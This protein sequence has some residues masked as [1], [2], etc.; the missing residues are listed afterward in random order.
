MPG[1]PLGVSRFHHGCGLAEVGGVEGVVV[2]G[3]LGLANPG[4]SVEWLGKGQ[5]LNRENY[6]VEKMLTYLHEIGPDQVGH[7]GQPCPAQTQP[8]HSQGG[9]H[10]QQRQHSIPRV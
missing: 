7:P 1:P 3:G 9:G 2:V 5:H 10:T 4:D 6:K 8:A